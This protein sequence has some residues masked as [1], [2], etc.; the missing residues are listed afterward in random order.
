MK[1]CEKEP[2][3]A[4]KIDKTLSTMLPSDGVLRQI[5]STMLPSYRVLR[6]QYRAKNLEVYSNLIHI[7][8]QAEKHDEL[9]LKNH[10]KRPVGSAPLPEVHNVQKKATSN[11]LNGPA[12]KNKSGQCKHNRK[13]RPNSNK[14]KRDNVRPTKDNKCQMW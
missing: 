1:F 9:L 13:Q 2:T 8:S 14:W 11:K 7:F 12:P 5:L 4:D 6:Q 10:H 3:D